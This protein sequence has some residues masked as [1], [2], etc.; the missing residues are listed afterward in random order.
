[1][2]D[3]QRSNCLC[4]KCCKLSKLNSNSD[5]DSENISVNDIVSVPELP[6]IDNTIIHIQGIKC[7][8]FLFDKSLRHD[9]KIGELLVP[10]YLVIKELI[11]I[12]NV[13][14]AN[15]NDIIQNMDQLLTLY[16]KDALKSR[17]L[18]DTMA[19]QIINSEL[20]ENKLHKIRPPPIS[21]IQAAFDMLIVYIRVLTRDIKFNRWRE[22]E[23]IGR[24]IDDLNN[25]LRLYGDKINTYGNLIN[26]EIRPEHFLKGDFIDEDKGFFWNQFQMVPSLSGITN[27]VNIQT[28]IPELDAVDSITKSG[29][30][31]QQNGKVS[32]S[33]THAPINIKPEIIQSPRSI[34]GFVHNDILNAGFNDALNFLLR[35]NRNELPIQ[36]FFANS[37][38]SIE[39]S[40]NLFFSEAGCGF[41]MALL[42]E[43]I[44]PA[45][46]EA[47]KNKWAF[48][49]IR[50]ERLAYYWNILFSE[51][52]KLTELERE[53]KSE[54]APV[55]DNHK[56]IF[57]AAPNIMSDIKNKNKNITKNKNGLEY[58]LLNLYP[59]GCPSHPSAP[60]GHSV[61]AGALGTMLKILFDCY[62]D[63][64][65]SSKLR[66]WQSSTKSYL[67]DTYNEKNLNNIYKLFNQSIYDIGNISSRGSSIEPNYANNKYVSIRRNNITVAGEIHKL[68]SQYTY[69]RDWGGAH[70]MSDGYIGLYIGQSVA[71]QFIQEKMKGF[72]SVNSGLKYSIILPTFNN[73]K[74]KIQATQLEYF[75]KQ[76]NRYIKIS[77]PE[78]LY[79]DY[80]KQKIVY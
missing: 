69:S 67:S 5:S 78:E 79:P 60:G 66:D 10:E 55:L 3:S 17:Y 29:Y 21:S 25:I 22:N 2:S 8:P 49:K 57:D 71:I 53:L 76:K 77:S 48:L 56:K 36:S 19:L 42:N 41:S 54:L 26:N 33:K 12:L 32:F 24:Y 62:V 4:N 28:Y 65:N 7:L 46:I 72:Y 14:G 20:G 23:N 44:R 73:I 64:N 15:G 37:N 1:M 63:K 59:E 39:N 27:K 9:T 11:E 6:L 47:W 68:C 30:N 52:N 80:I 35:C 16:N 74:I 75:D 43:I 13:N 50:P 34:I 51:E 45:L 61:V 18:V 40:T 70:Y 38:L 31:D 58:L